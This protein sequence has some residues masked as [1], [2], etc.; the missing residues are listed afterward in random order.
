MATPEPYR[1]TYLADVRPADGYFHAFRVGNFPSLYPSIRR[2]VGTSIL[3]AGLVA[4]AI[5]LAFSLL[6]T[7]PGFRRWH[8]SMRPSLISVYT[9]V[10][11]LAFHDE[12][13]SRCPH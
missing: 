3:L 5:I 4:A 1:D 11:M 13:P 6:L 10:E 7:V 9:V 8:V 2:P 12:L